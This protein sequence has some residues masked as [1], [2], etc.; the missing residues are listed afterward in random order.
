MW[1]EHAKT[2]IGIP[3][4]VK[5]TIDIVNLVR[6]GEKSPTEAQQQLAM[7]LS[8]LNDF[9]H[10]ALEL[11]AYKALHTMTSSMMTDL[12]ETFTIVGSDEGRARNQYND[13]LQLIEY[14]FTSLW[15]GHR[16]GDKLARLRGTEKYMQ[17][18][19]N[20][21]K[22][23]MQ[24]VRKP[25]WEDYLWTLLHRAQQER[26]NFKNFHGCVRDLRTLNVAL[27][28]YADHMIALGIDEFDKVMEHL[29]VELASK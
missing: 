11:A 6:S 2:L 1:W 29:R 3:G 14:E 10:D 15:D 7:I 20:P 8:G 22:T 26:E 27:N 23:V 19:R 4:A 13:S 24:K 21:P 5:A 28:N 16:A 9:A 18:L 25:P 12:K 17:F